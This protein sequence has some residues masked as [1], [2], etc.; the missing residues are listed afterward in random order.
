MFLCKKNQSFALTLSLNMVSMVLVPYG[1]NPNFDIVPRVMVTSLR[2]NFAVRC[3]MSDSNP[4][5]RN[6]ILKLKI[7]NS[8]NYNICINLG[9]G[10]ERH[11]TL[12]LE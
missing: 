1:M 8:L 9:K 5:I 3:V 11:Q 6:K 4:Y 12:F 2:S 7:V 10:T